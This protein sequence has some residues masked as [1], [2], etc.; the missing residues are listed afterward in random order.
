MA[1]RTSVPKR[2]HASEKE[3]E[4]AVRRGP[5]AATERGTRRSTRRE[6]A[7]RSG[8]RLRAAEQ[9]GRRR[10]Q[11]GYGGHHL[12]HVVR[13]R[14]RGDPSSTSKKQSS[15][16]ME[17][18]RS[19]PPTPTSDLPASSSRSP[20]SPLFSLAIPTTSTRCSQPNRNRNSQIQ[21]EIGSR[22]QFGG[23]TPDDISRGRADPLAPCCPW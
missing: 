20:P 4:P 19:I 22:L 21:I 8:R 10:S 18:P 11:G 12:V 15:A 1:P 9:G 23:L 2:P 3:R 7:E 16:Q 17:P 14:A 5:G 6:R 13:R